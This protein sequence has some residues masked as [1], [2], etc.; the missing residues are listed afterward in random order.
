MESRAC[1]SRSPDNAAK[2]K[3]SRDDTSLGQTTRSR[4]SGAT[5]SRLAKST[6]AKFFPVKA[7]YL[8]L[9]T[10]IATA[11]YAS[12]GYCKAQGHRRRVSQSRR[13]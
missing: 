13:P 1:Q 11:R 2:A 7:G 6:R 8:K 3:A 12:V 5:T 10:I 9:M 4:N